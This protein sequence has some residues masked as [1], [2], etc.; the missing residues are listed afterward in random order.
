MQ[1]PFALS[2]TQAKTDAEEE[3]V[4][5]ASIKG[6]KKHKS[7]KN[8]DPSPGAPSDE[9]AKK[10]EEKKAAKHSGE[11]Q[12]ATAEGHGSPERPKK[13]KN[14]SKKEGVVIVDDPKTHTHEGDPTK[15]T[16]SSNARKSTLLLCDNA[17][18]VALGNLVAIQV[19]RP[20]EKGRSI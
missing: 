2:A 5:P 4:E 7:K 18:A 10:K 3:R 8:R 14:K 9:N 17:A 1:G 13:K 20:T 12:E 11:G 15:E 6:N 19:R 16:P